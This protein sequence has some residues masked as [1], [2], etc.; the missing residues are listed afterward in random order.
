MAAQGGGSTPPPGQNPAYR[1]TRV[2]AGPIRPVRPEENYFP[3]GLN[4][5]ERDARFISHN[6]P[7]GKWCY[8]SVCVLDDR[9][10]IAH[11]YTPYIEHP[12]DAQLIYDTAD[13]F[14][15]KPTGK[16]LCQ[17]LKVLPLK[18]FYGGKDP[19]NNPFLETA[20]EPAKP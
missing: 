16:S 1:P 15:D 11:T 10:L 18:W 2:E 17:K 14:V 8:P 13:E 20:Y 6:G 3:A 19:A 12:T 7:G 4:A 9:V 5:P